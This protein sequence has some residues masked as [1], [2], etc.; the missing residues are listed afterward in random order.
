MVRLL[1]LENIE[2]NQKFDSALVKRL[3][4]IIEFLPSLED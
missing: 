1:Q 2:R 4:E 3:S